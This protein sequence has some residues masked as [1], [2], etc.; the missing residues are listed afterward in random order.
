[1]CFVR[2]FFSRYGIACQGEITP[3]F[4][5]LSSAE[6]KR[7]SMSL[8]YPPCPRR[9]PRLN[10][11]TLSTTLVRL[12]LHSQTICKEFLLRSQASHKEKLP[13]PTTPNHGFQQSARSAH[14]S[15]R[16][17]SSSA[18]HPIC[19]LVNPCSVLTMLCKR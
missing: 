14:L 10:T 19:M 6:W 13:H 2:A 8:C 11:D 5:Q 4:H 16:D 17:E 15:K 7:T 12:H 9:K 3:W 18:L 1:M